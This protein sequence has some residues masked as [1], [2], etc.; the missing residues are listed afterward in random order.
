[1]MR[2]AAVGC[3]MFVLA[4]CTYAQNEAQVSCLAQETTFERTDEQQVLLWT[5]RIEGGDFPNACVRSFFVRS[6][7]CCPRLCV[8]LFAFLSL[9][10]SCARLD[11]LAGAIRR[12]RRV[13]TK[14]AGQVLSGVVADARLENCE[15]IQ[16]ECQ[17]C[18]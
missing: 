7:L 12:A 1:M 10:K 8:F 4:P 13:Q 17:P 14:G 9:A 2:L 16:L 5:G 3:L 15:I 18:P 6:L 11:L